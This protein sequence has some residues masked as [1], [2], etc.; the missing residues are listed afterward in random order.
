MQPSKHTDVAV[1]AT[2]MDFTGNAFAIM[3]KYDHLT[4][5]VSTMVIVT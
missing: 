5:S 1:N 3:M 4:M 2:E